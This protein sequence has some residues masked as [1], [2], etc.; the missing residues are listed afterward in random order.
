MDGLWGG[1]GGR[2]YSRVS[3]FMHGVAAERDAVAVVDE[4]AKDGVGEGRI[5]RYMCHCSTGNWLAIRVDFLS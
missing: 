2:R 3:P 4:A 1:G 5:A